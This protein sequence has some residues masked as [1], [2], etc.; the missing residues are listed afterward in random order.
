VAKSLE[1]DLAAKN[2]TLKASLCR[3]QIEVSDNRLSL[4]GTFPPK[5]GTEGSKPKQA[6]IRL[7]I[8][9]NSAGLA[10]AFT[11]AKRAGLELEDGSFDWA[12][13][14][15]TAPV[16]EVPGNTVA[17]WLK[18]YEASYFTRRARTDKS[19]GTWDGDYYYVI[20]RMDQ[21]AELNSATVLKAISAIDPALVKTR[22]RACTTLRGLCRFAGLKLD[23]DLSQYRVK[24]AI[25]PVQP[26]SLPTDEEILRVYY[27]IPSKRKDLRWAYGAWATWGLRPGEIYLIENLAEIRSGITTLHISAEAK[28]GKPRQAVA[29]YPEWF[30]EFDL[31]NVVL[32]DMDM[33]R[34]SKKRGSLVSRRFEK[35]L[36]FRPYLLRHRYAFRLHEAGVDVLD[37]AR[38]MGHAM[39]VHM[40]TYLAGVDTK[41]LLARVELAQ[42]NPNR[43]KAPTKS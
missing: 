43:P 2:E 3:I 10:K 29:F 20:I 17:D 1:Q 37:A 33:K 36:D 8:S 12:N 7:G 18:R 24:K 6:R 5:P 25:T 23:F 39:K 13:W 21:A 26:D 30:D 32:P 41:K 35:I 27:T 19:Q 4:R 15:Y 16:T 28:N 38:L 14:G 40:D 22:N 42:S 11:K 34:P 31:K 9:A